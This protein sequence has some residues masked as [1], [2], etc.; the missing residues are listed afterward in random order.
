MTTC[1]ECGADALEQIARV[2]LEGNF[3]DRENAEGEIESFVELDDDASKAT[4]LVRCS[5]CGYE[6]DDGDEA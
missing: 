1:P 2:E 3:Q 5:A 6:A 4:K